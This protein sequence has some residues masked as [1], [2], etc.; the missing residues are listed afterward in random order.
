M[1]VRYL[2]KRPGHKRYSRGKHGYF[3]WDSEEDK[4]KLMKLFD[5]FRDVVPGRKWTRLKH[6]EES[7]YD[8][9]KFIF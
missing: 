6:I 7:D 2:E 4:A 8:A 3:T 1:T 5:D 9:Y